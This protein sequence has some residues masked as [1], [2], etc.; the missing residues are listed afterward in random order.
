MGDLLRAG[1]PVGSRDRPPGRLWVRPPRCSRDQQ[2]RSSRLRT[3]L[4]I[5]LPGEI[6]CCCRQ[7]DR[8][9]RD[10]PI[11]C[12]VDQ[13][14]AVP[15]SCASRRAPDPAPGPQITKLPEQ[16]SALMTGIHRRGRRSG[17][18]VGVVAD[19]VPAVGTPT[20]ELAMTRSMHRHGDMGR[21]FS[22]LAAN[23]SGK[24]WIDEASYVTRH[25][26]VFIANYR[27]V[28]GAD[29]GADA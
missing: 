11:R 16:S 27:S 26:A 12:G 22:L 13:Q 10:V 20:S 29:G 4:S 8:F 19:V 17:D 28:F 21:M 23:P 24:R 14:T 7:M 1:R 15:S 2:G 25:L 9:H 5:I 3:Q 18:V 6:I